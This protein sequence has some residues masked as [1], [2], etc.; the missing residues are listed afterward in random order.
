MLP[1]WIIPQNTSMGQP[2]SYNRILIFFKNHYVMVSYVLLSF[3]PYRAQGILFLLKC[4]GGSEER[5]GR[6]DGC[7]GT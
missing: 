4:G 5:W 1:V 3:L 7:V 6:Q 2:S